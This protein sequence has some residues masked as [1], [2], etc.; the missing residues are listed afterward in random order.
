MEW[1][2]NTK[3]NVSLRYQ[4]NKGLYTLILTHWVKEARVIENLSRSYEPSRSDQ[5]EL[6]WWE[7]YLSTANNMFIV[8]Q[9][10]SNKV[11]I[12]NILQAEITYQTS[13]SFVSFYFITITKNFL[14]K[15]FEI[16]KKI[17]KGHQAAA[18][19]PLMPISYIQL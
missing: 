12:P 18:G 1:K 4:V 16:L 14:L 8:T 7:L 2:T 11:T 6:E 10:S 3:M 13:S 9:E 5:S 19:P 15:Y 17:F